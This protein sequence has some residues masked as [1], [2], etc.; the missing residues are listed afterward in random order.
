MHIVGKRRRARLHQFFLFVAVG[1]LC[2][3][4]S[5]AASSNCSS[6]VSSDNTIV[7][8][9][10]PSVGMVRAR[11]EAADWFGGG[12]RI[13]GNAAE[14]GYIHHLARQ[15]KALGTSDVTEEPYT[16]TTWS[17]SRYTLDVLNGPSPGPVEVAYFIPD[18]GVTG[19]A[20]LT[21]PLT[22]FP[23]A[24]VDFSGA[25][26]AALSRRDPGN[27][28]LAIQ[29]ALQGATGGGVPLEQAIA[30]SDLRGKIVVYDAPDFSLPVGLFEL[31]SVYVNNSGH[32]F[33]PL[34]P[35]Q[36]PY[37]NELLTIGF[38]NELFKLSGAAGVIAVLNYPAV[39][40]DNSYVPFGTSATPSIPGL[41]VDST[42]GAALKQQ[43]AAAQ[44]DSL[45][46]RLTLEV[47][48]RPA[49]SYNVSAMIPGACSNQILVSS[50]TDGP[51]SIEDNGP[52]AILSIADYF[53]RAP[54][55]Q[56]LRGLR[57]VLTGGHFESSVGIN[58]YIARHQTD[59]D[60]QVL[61]A[62][63]IEHLGAREWLQL[64]P[65]VMGLDGLAEPMVLYSDSGTVQ[66]DENVTFARN[67]DR[68]LVTIPLPFG[69]GLAWSQTAGLP[70][71]QEI[72]GPVYLLN[73]PLRQVSTEFTDYDLERQEIDAFVQM[74][75][76][77]NTQPASIL[78][79][80]QG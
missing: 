45:Q 33:G 16:F 55:S 56:R 78:K 72:T 1:L 64:S 23:S 39:A 58:A 63:E 73:G 34:T 40:A 14:L 53:L 80:P 69:E 62:I 4:G 25:A 44:A 43:I 10:L 22:Y 7:P 9:L 31:L 29:T 32:S 49:T 6:D 57:I 2:S 42:Q 17:P 13:D 74:I 11:Q 3:F 30:A 77:L 19:A 35:Y 46:A 59:L 47:S 50:H 8:R 27:V 37:I 24:N 52:A 66:E 65:G 79:P 60:S 54:A 71:I 20:G 51:N 76:N 38:V 70:E 48:Q 68:S 36:R 26:L 21:A 67:F 18:S 5:S 75:L 28:S 12:F 61:T 41:Y 15:L